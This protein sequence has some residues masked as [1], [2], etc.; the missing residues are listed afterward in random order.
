MTQGQDQGHTLPQKTFCTGILNNV[1]R[2]LR[3]TVNNLPHMVKPP[4]SR[5]ILKLAR[6][7]EKSIGPYASVKMFHYS[8]YTQ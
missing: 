3:L 5:V 1:L 6:G 7:R 4:I 2:N 8:R